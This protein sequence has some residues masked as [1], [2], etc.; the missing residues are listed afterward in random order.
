MRLIALISFVL[1]MAC[2]R[3]PPT[4][5]VIR[6]VETID[7]QALEPWNPAR[8]SWIT[9]PT[10]APVTELNA[11]TALTNGLMK[12]ETPETLSATPVPEDIAA[13]ARIVADRLPMGLHWRTEIKQA[14]LDIARGQLR[15]TTTHAIE[16]S[17]E[18][19][20]GS[21]PY[22]QYDG[23]HDRL[24]Y[25][26]PG[27]TNLIMRANLVYA[28]AER[29][30][31]H[32]LARL[33]GVPARTYALT[34]RV[35]GNLRAEFK[36]VTYLQAMESMAAW[37]NVDPD[38]QPESAYTHLNGRFLRST[39]H[40]GSY[41]SLDTLLSSAWSRAEQQRQVMLDA[42][43]RLSILYFG[44]AEEFCGRYVIARGPRRGHYLV[45]SDDLP[46]ILP[47]LEHVPAITAASN[48]RPSA[49]TPDL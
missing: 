37:I 44:H 12:V 7:Q 41:P 4:S 19:A 27:E 36:T 15:V 16:R 6:D 48:D 38:L 22:F 23:V 28:L 31:L 39:T 13:A 5:Q 40:A 42:W 10:H 8:P 18:L 29:A 26:S 46:T 1:L 49:P 17:S 45:P 35:C 20:T 11:F 30:H 33:A 9:L 43:N 14:A 25:E 24:V 34:L 3:E 32:D 21:I 47:Y 2:R